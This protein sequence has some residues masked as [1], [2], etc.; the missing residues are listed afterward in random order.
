[1]DCLF[2]QEYER[3][4][5]NGNP[6]KDDVQNA[7]QN[8]Y[9][10]YMELSHKDG[11][12]DYMQ[13][14]KDVN[15]LLLKIQL[16]ENIN[17]CFRSFYDPDLVAILKQ[18]NLNPGINAE[19]DFG[20]IAKKMQKVISRAKRW[21]IEHKEKS[22][23]LEAMEKEA[24]KQSGGRTAF[25]DALSALSR[26][27]GYGVKP[28]EISVLRFVTESQRLEQYMRRQLLKNKRG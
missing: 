2:D 17:T 10:E 27:Y 26:H 3:L 21:A 7:W 23:R 6:N 25:E 28:S 15:V 8:L 4:I 16:V 5:I 1:M 24:S 14:V 22:E 18:L 12:T 11:M 19:D 20:T 9:G 13:L